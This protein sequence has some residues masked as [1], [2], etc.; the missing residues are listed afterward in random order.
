MNDENNEVD[1]LQA[2][3]AFQVK[4]ILPKEKISPYKHLHSNRHQFR[5]SGLISVGFLDPDPLIRAE[6]PDCCSE[7]ARDAMKV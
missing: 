7:R 6:T 1:L 5:E 4:E 2:Y 3:F